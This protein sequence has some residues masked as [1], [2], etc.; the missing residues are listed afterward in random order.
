MKSWCCRSAGVHPR[1]GSL[2]HP[3]SMFATMVAKKQSTAS[4]SA[5]RVSGELAINLSVS[6]PCAAISG[7]RPTQS[8]HGAAAPT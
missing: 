1:G 6:T 2:R 8:T 4:A 7:S 5:S 3:P